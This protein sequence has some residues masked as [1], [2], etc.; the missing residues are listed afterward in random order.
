MTICHHLTNTLALKIRQTLI[1]PK[2][3]SSMLYVYPTIEIA[4]TLSGKH[5]AKNKTH[6]KE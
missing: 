5:D 4:H 3:T 6:T 1:Q 2:N